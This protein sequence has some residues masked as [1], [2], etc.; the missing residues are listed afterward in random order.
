VLSSSF[1]FFVYLTCFFEKLLA[2]SHSA[3]AC[4]TPSTKSDIARKIS[5]AI[6]AIN[7]YAIAIS[8]SPPAS[9]ADA[10][11]QVLEVNAISDQFGAGSPHGR[12]RLLAVTV[13][14]RYLREI[15][16]AFARIIPASLLPG[17]L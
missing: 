2:L 16:H 11:N 8:S 10:L 12:Q 15:H 13:D 6:K 3:V 1:S 17:C 4:V 9:A 5:T 7:R 14:D